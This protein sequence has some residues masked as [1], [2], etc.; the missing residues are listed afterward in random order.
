MIG[1]AKSWKRGHH[2]AVRSHGT[3]ASRE[4]QEVT[5]EEDS[6]KKNFGES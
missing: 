2:A 6:E 5:D 3:S 4:Q 1:L